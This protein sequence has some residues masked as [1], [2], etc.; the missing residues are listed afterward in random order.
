MTHT[1]AFVAQE[2]VKRLRK[3]LASSLPDAVKV[4]VQRQLH[5]ELA[6]LGAENVIRSEPAP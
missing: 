5:I 3:L 2:N 1:D 4:E 6:K